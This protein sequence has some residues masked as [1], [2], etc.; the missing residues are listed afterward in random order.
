MMF[1]PALA[2]MFGLVC[3]AA[4]AAELGV[5]AS[6]GNG[7]DDSMRA[8]SA[9]THAGPAAVADRQQFAPI[10]ASNDAY[11]WRYPYAFPTQAPVMAGHAVTPPAAVVRSRR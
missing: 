9:G 4:T 10:P 5:L 3:A 11:G 6:A 7:G 1:K 8:V 2:V